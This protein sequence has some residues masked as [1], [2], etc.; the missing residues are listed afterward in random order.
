[1]NTNTNRSANIVHPLPLAALT[2]KNAAK[3]NMGAGASTNT[4]GDRRAGA[5]RRPR[6]DRASSRQTTRQWSMPR[7]R[8]AMFSPTT[9][10][11]KRRRRPSSPP[12]EPASDGDRSSFQPFSVSPERQTGIV[13][14]WL[15]RDTMRP[16]W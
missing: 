12:G 9:T 8:H 16:S 6:A 3:L 1:M 15:S 10:E 11:T 13:W 14:G 2:V 4:I 7:H 5:S